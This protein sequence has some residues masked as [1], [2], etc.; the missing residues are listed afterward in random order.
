MYN[1]LYTDNSSSKFVYTSISLQL[2]NQVMSFLN[3]KLPWRKSSSYDK[4]CITY[5]N[6]FLQPQQ[7]RW[8]SLNRKN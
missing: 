7:N 5:K 3:W 6:K 1:I 4:A 2:K 8:Q